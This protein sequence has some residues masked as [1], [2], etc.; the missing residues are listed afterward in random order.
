MSI[1]NRF[2]KKEKL[3]Q[4][5]V[6]IENSL[7]E[8]LEYLSDNVYEATISGLINEC[9][10]FLLENETINVYPKIKDEIKIKRTIL[11]RESNVEGLEML[12]EKYGI[13]VSKL[14]NIAIKNAVEN[15]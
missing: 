6:E 5:T 2:L 11:I 13:S 9:I 7:F 4:K 14:I 12:K 15:L 1:F 8:K 10:C 3:C